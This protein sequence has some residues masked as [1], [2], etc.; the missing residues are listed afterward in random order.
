MQNIQFRYG[1][2]PEGQ[3][4]FWPASRQKRKEWLEIKRMRPVEAESVYQCNPGARAGVIFLEDDFCYYKAP[5]GLHHGISDPSVQRFVE[6]G[7]MVIQSW[8]TAMSA[9]SDADYSVCT[10]AL[11]V[12]SDSYHRGEDVITMGECEQH[13]VVYL[14]DVYRERLDIGDLIKAGREQF[15][16]WKPQLVVI[17]KKAHGS[18]L[19]QSL[20]NTGIPVEGVDPVDS[21]RERTVT[22][23]GQAA[24]SVQGW[25]RLHRVRVPTDL[26]Q[27][28]DWVPDFKRELKDFTGQK[29]GK[30]DQVDSMVLAVS[31]GIREGGSNIHFP[32]GWQNPDDIDANMTKEASTPEVDFWAQINEP[33][34]MDDPFNGLCGRCSNYTSPM[35]GL[36]NVNPRKEGELPGMCRLW[37]SRKTAI[38]SCEHFTTPYD[39]PLFPRRSL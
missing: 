5:E 10:T 20:E 1:V 21:K 11:L 18:A 17:E 38:D 16:K 31:Y 4:F 39:T 33:S 7:T 25:F 14:L 28:V 36:E 26:P 19:M 34:S 37:K 29:G 12:P 2:D 9:K 32:T 24:G 35:R 23:I 30:D 3:G 27:D 13:Y 22:A 15:I 8:D 6:R